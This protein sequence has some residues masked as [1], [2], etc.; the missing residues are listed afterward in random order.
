MTCAEPRGLGTG[1]LGAPSR[2]PFGPDRS[3][4]CDRSRLAV[5]AGT[6]RPAVRREGFSVSGRYRAQ[7]F[8]YQVG[9]RNQAR[10]DCDSLCQTTKP[11]VRVSREYYVTSTRLTTIAES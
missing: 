1:S 3:A 6:R 4:Q 9:Q 2:T 11:G 5:V 8:A 10:F 7:V